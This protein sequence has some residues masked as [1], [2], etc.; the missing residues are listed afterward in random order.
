[1]LFMEHKSALVRLSDSIK[2]GLSSCE[3]FTSEIIELYSLYEVEFEKMRGIA[4]QILD[5]KVNAK[6]GEKEIHRV[7][8]KIPED[9]PLQGA[10]LQ[11]ELHS[12]ALSTILTCCFCLESYINSLAYHLFQ[13]ADYLGLLRGGHDV[14]SDLLIEALEKM[15][16]IKKWET[17]A[18]IGNSKGFDKSRYPFQDFVCLFNFRNDHVHDKVIDFSEN[19]SKKRYNSKLPDPISGLLNL[20]HALYAADIYWAMVEEIHSLIDFE[21][22][23]FH[24]HY[25]LKPWVSDDQKKELEK[26]SDKYTLKFPKSD[27]MSS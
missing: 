10:Q 20:K 16:T 11:S 12:Q 13:E 18:K 17:V 7:I 22:N 9:V 19:R 15:R 26:L 3:R 4:K 24:R 6:E 25:N 27:F 8:S 5:E 23:S 2:V 1:M 14:T 21:V